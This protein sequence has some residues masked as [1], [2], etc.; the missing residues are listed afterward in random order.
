[1]PSL[2]GSEMCI[3]RQGGAS[4]AGKL[5]T[6]PGWPSFSARTAIEWGGASLP[7]PLPQAEEENG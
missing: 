1:M 2:V 6:I 5:P 3:K 7:D 4:I